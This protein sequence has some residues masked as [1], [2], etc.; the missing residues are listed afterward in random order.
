MHGCKVLQWC[1]ATLQVSR[2]KSSNPLIGLRP[3]NYNLSFV[4][5]ACLRTDDQSTTAAAGLVGL[6][7][8][9]ATVCL[10]PIP[11][12][13]LA[14]KLKIVPQPSHRHDLDTYPNSFVSRRPGVAFELSYSAMCVEKWSTSLQRQILFPYPLSVPTQHNSH[15]SRTTLLRHESMKKS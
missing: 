4:Q 10:H 7:D 3:Q 8:P 5:G 12:Y 11:L 15:E 9:S 13:E 14:S 1:C 2:W 6:L